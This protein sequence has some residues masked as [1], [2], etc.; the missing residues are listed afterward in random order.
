M[1]PV[2]A[3]L[4]CG[5]EHDPSKP[6]TMEHASACMHVL[7][8]EYGAVRRAVSDFR[9][10]QVIEDVPTPSTNGAGGKA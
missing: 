5:E 7:E 8:A 3:C 4:A 2:L 9:E 1:R 6:S 10:A